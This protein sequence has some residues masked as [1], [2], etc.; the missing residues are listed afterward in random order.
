MATV[1]ATRPGPV[2]SVWITRA[3][4]GAPPADYAQ[5]PPATSAR[6][7]VDAQALT[8]L[9]AGEAPGVRAARIDLFRRRWSVE[10]DMPGHALI[11]LAADYR[12]QDPDAAGLYA[13]WLL[14]H[15]PAGYVIAYA[16]RLRG[17]TVPGETP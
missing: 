16:A 4:D 7:A 6:A 12:A 17:V 14:E 15:E 8:A 3:V 1:Y 13:A 5:Y 2:G 11:D 10:R 9:A